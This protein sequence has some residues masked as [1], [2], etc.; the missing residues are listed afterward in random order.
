M[1]I[2]NN[3]SKTEFINDYGRYSNDY[4]LVNSDGS[5]N[6]IISIAFFMFI[7]SLV[8]FIVLFVIY[9]K[10][11]KKEKKEMKNKMLFF[12]GLLCVTIATITLLSG[13]VN[14]I[15]YLG[16]FDKWYKSLPSTGKTAYQKMTSMS[17]IINKLRNHNMENN[18]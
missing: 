2:I 16:Q 5:K 6:G 14:M 8:G 3:I 7:L 15:L 4:S 1:D 11:T 9:S 17:S 12:G 18:M 10:K 13:S